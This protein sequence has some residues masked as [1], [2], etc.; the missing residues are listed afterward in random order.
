MNGY[1]YH[2]DYTNYQ[3]E[4]GMKREQRMKSMEHGRFYGIDEVIRGMAH[5]K[6]VETM[7]RNKR[8]GVVYKVSNAVTIFREDR[9]PDKKGEKL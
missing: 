1:N 4:R 7:V 3:T 8:N 6:K 5:D 9:H 2:D